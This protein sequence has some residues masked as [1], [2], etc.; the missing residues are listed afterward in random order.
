MTSRTPAIRPD[1]LPRDV[2]RGLVESM[3]ADSGS[4][5]FGAVVT[6]LNGLLIAL[7]TLS[8]TSAVATAAIV[9]VTVFR[10]G[11][12]KEYRARERSRDVTD[13]RWLE[14]TYLLGV[15]AYLLCIGLLAL[16]AFT[17]SN[18]PFV[19]TLSCAT[20]VIHALSIAVRNFAFPKWG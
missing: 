6:S 14:R 17:A 16:T 13:A 2:R 3:F 9:G 10:L 4:M 15:S 20:A 12:I 19:L 1:A 8:W 7:L 11:L 18:D 5:V